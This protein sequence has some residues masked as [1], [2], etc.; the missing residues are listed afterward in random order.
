MA[1]FHWSEKRFARRLAK[2][3]LAS[4]HA[5]RSAHPDLQGTELYQPVLMRGLGYDAGRA[6]T[7]VDTAERSISWWPHD[8][9]LR[10]RDVV[11]YVAVSEFA[12]RSAREHPGTTVTFRDIIDRIIP[13]DV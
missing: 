3:Q 1:L 12:Q 10:F 5:V 7:V 9:E 11:H 6:A 2:Q 13:A 8:R 4:L